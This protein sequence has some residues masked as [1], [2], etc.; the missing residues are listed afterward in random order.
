MFHNTPTSPHQGMVTPSQLEGSDIPSS[1]T[2]VSPLEFLEE[3]MTPLPQ[4]S[5]GAWGWWLRITA[6]PQPQSRLDARR[7]EQLRRSHLLSFFLLVL[8]GAI[9]VLFPKAFIPELDFGLLGGLFLCSGIAIGSILLNHYRLMNAA[10]SVF[11]IGIAVA[12]AFALLA[13]PNGLG[14]QDLPTFDMFVIPIILAGILLPRRSPFLICSRL[15][16]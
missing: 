10:A 16:Y 4:H 1:S 5:R 7:R 3:S 11:V 2:P 9:V 15:D 13:T 8:L 12:I 6:P 14:M